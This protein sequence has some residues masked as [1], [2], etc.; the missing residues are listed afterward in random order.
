[1][2]EESCMTDEPPPPLERSPRRLSRDAFLTILS[3]TDAQPWLKDHQGELVALIDECATEDEQV[4]VCELLERFKYLDGA[5]FTRSVQEI[6]L[7][8]ENHLALSP[9][10][11]LI[12][13]RENSKYSDSSQFVVYQLKCSNWQ[14]EN[15][16][17]TS[18]INKLS[19]VGQMAPANV[20]LVDEF[21]GT[22]KTMEKSVSWLRSKQ[23]EWAV[24]FNIHVAVVA[25]MEAG[26]ERVTAVADSVF[27][28]HTLRKGITD[29]YESEIASEKIGRMLDIEKGLADE[30]K[31]GKLSEHSLGYKK[32]EALYSRVGGNTP[33]NVFPIFW[34]E[35]RANGQARSSLLRCM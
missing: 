5:E 30:G 27:A 28:I 1:M 19:D 25:G 15:W 11:T 21:V 4:L 13:A 2:I 35:K 23:S 22:G 34:W 7:H 31:R 18:F 3:L 26:L 17:T 20:V 12:A 8:I 24:A 32:T 10:N 6:A 14:N 16:L 29:F 33:N 9:P